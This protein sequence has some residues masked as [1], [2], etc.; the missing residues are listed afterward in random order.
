MIT[1]IRC[2][3]AIIIL[4][5]SGCRTIE[6]TSYWREGEIKIDGNSDEWQGKTWMIKD[7][8]N[9]LFGFMND[10][11]YLY[12][13]FTF[14][15]RTLQRQVAM[16]GLTIWFDRKGGNEK[17]FGIHYPLTM[18]MDMPPMRR[19]PRPDVDHGI[20]TTF[21][22]PENFSDELEIYG[23]VENEH[24]R[25]RL[26]ETGGIEISLRHTMGSLI[27][28]MKVPLKD[29]G[30]Q[31]Y[32]IGANAGSIIG[33]GIET[34][35]FGKLGFRDERPS[36]NGGFGERMGGR[37]PGDGPPHDMRGVKEPLNVWLKLKLE[38]NKTSHFN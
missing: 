22:F 11:D 28:E 6:L 24:N 12:L 27:Y 8:K 5:L 38:S 32:V 1:T 18:M 37:L 21:K 4:F 34:T 16:G 29:K 14:G 9:V 23:P 36:M 35:D 17:R 7:I 19:L 15:D 13:L 3:T 33:I 20:D 31:P 2:L 30:P 25:M 26:Q 10:D